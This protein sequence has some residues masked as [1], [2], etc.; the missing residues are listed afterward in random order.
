VT[1]GLGATESTTLASSL[2][3]SRIGWDALDERYHPLLR[4]VD[5]LLGV[6]PNCDRYLE[7]W[8]P[9]FRAYNIMV[10]NLLNLPVPVMGVGGP[11]AGVV[12]LAMY[13]ASRTAGCPYC[14]AHSC[15]FAMRRGASPAEVASALLPG[16]GSFDRGQLAAITVARSLARVPCELTP[17]E[18]A[19]LVDVYG[20]QKAEWIV[21]A[22]VMMGFLN[23]FMDALGVELEQSVVDEVADTMGA[24]WSP[25]HAGAD[26]DPA[27]PRRPAPPIDGWRTRLG[28]LP[29]LPGAIRYD[30]R[31]QRGMPS[32]ARAIAAVLQDSVGHDF[33]VLATVRSNRARRA[34]ASMLRE[35]L[36]PATS[37]VG[38]ETKLRVA[39][40][41]AAAVDG[42]ALTEDIQ[43]LAR[44]AGVDLDA[45]EAETAATALARAASPSPARIDAATI[46]ACEQ[47]DLSGAAI[48]EVVAWLA[49]LQLLHRLSCWAD[50]PARTEPTL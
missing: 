25:S 1:N 7:I 22:V 13:V 48:V 29:S 31:I 27:S 20:E 19:D 3:G 5:K 38:I 15:S 17:E 37:V 33:P 14:S 46:A 26:L 43:T 18:K 28:L 32:K 6:V 36:D 34:I 11:P 24:G 10:P 42:A 39:A 49:V 44:H 21:L 23:K 16:E 41:Y 30:R 8:P 45:A 2:H 12:G 50:P 35:N 47:A 40:V 4:L 9:A